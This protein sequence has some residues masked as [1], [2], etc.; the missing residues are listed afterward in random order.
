M[1]KVPLYGFNSI[2]PGG[3]NLNPPPTWPGVG[4]LKPLVALGSVLLTATDGICSLAAPG[5]PNPGSPPG[6]GSGVL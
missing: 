3:G 1:S 2:Y 5:M 6:L 4:N